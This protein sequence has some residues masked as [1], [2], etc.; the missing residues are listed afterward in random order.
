MTEKPKIPAYPRHLSA[1]EALG[2]LNLWQDRHASWMLDDANK[3]VGSDG[4]SLPCTIDLVVQLHAR[5][6]VQGRWRDERIEALEKQVA[7][8]LAKVAAGKGKGKP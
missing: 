1:D 6:V 3:A 8:L 2:L 5:E 7:E 4:R